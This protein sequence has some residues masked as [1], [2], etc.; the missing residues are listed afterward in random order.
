MMARANTC[1]LRQ[2][3]HR[4]DQSD[5]F[6]PCTDDEASPVGNGRP[7]KDMKFEG[8]LLQDDRNPT[9]RKLDQSS[10]CATWLGNSISS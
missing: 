7:A 2:R 5:G 9:Y 1:T 8:G 4:D 3:D 10:P 6:M